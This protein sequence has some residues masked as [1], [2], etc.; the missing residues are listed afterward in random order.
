LS[1]KPTADVLA[2]EQDLD[3]LGVSS[4]WRHDQDRTGFGRAEIFR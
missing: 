3:G 2:T 1:G 4:G